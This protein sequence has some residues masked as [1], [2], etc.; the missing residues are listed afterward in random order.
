MTPTPLDTRE[1]W[2]ELVDQH[3]QSGLT[4]AAFCEARGISA[5]SLYTWRKRFAAPAAASTA[6]ALSFVAVEPIEDEP[7]SAQPLELV[8][9][10]GRCVR[11][12]VGFDAHT[13][14]RLVGIVE[15]GV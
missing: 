2:H 4:V 15:G 10:G 14:Q 1:R 5:P 3:A 6:L 8:L 13:L 12:P 11:I 9:R 7:S